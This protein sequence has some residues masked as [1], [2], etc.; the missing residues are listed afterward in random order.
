MLVC[1]L[2]Y[3]TKYKTQT[4]IM[5]NY[6]FWFLRTH[7]MVMRVHTARKNILVLGMCREGISPHDKQEARREEDTKD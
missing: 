1:F 2:V 6:L 5:I 3:V 7:P 4:T